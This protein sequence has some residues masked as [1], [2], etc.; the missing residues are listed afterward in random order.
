MSW[1]RLIG[2]RL[3]LETAV[4]LVTGWGPGCLWMVRPPPMLGPTA[5]FARQRPWEGDGLLG[6]ALLVSFSRTPSGAYQ[7]RFEKP[8]RLAEPAPG[9][10]LPASL[11]TAF[12]IDARLESME[13]CFLAWGW[14]PGGLPDYDP[15]HTRDP[16]PESPCPPSARAKTP[17]TPWPR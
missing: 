2:V 11:G 16:T 1:Y 4:E 14:P 6:Y 17:L 8:I 10:A 5:I 9:A 3:P 12:M 15:A 13:V 7:W